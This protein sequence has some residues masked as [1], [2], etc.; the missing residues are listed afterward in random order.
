MKSADNT[1][2][3]RL[4]EVRGLI[5]SLGRQLRIHERRQA[6]NPNDWGFPGDLT[7]IADRL[8]EIT[9]QHGDRRCGWKHPKTTMYGCGH[10]AAYCT[11]DGRLVCFEH[12]PESG[13]GPDECLDIETGLPADDDAPNAQLRSLTAED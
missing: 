1:Y 3:E 6:A 13:F 4:A 9:P 10:N 2:Q 5:E 8:R 11:P 12:A 7:H